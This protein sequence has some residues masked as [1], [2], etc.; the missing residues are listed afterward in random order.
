MGGRELLCKVNRDCLRD[1]LGESLDVFEL[2]ARPLRGTGDLVGA[3]RGFID[4]LTPTVIDEVISRIRNGHFDAIFVDGSNLGE[5][6]S[7]IKKN[8]PQMR[9][10]TFFHNVE[11]LFF[12]GAFK[13][14]RSLRSAAVLVA[15]FLAERKSVRA[16]DAIVVMSEIDS[17]NLSRIF[18]RAADVKCP[19]ALDEYPKPR[20]V[21]DGI[22]PPSERYLLFVGGAFYAN[23]AGIAWFIQHVAPRIQMK[24]IVVGKGMEFLRDELRPRGNVEII[25]GVP[26]VEKWYSN[27]HVAIAPIFDGS[28]M[29]T[30]VAEA[31]MFG[32]QIIGTKEAFAGYEGDVAGMGWECDSADEFVQK[33]RELEHTELPRFNQA[34]RAIFNQNYSFAAA[35]ARLKKIIEDTSPSE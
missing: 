8:F 26:S 3:M 4:G 12:L 13:R 27:A 11:T 34:A 17:V 5:I 22:T 18:G 29:K 2:N 6:V 14:S 9:I 16:S 35:R 20:D 1:I 28:G 30:K 24:T 31:L 21:D 25:G 7:V 19:M 15:N 23:K 33:I 32:K 10:V